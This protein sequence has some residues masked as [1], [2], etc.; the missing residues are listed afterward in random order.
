MVNIHV[1][2]SRPYKHSKHILRNDD[3]FT[4]YLKGN[5][6]WFLGETFSNY[7]SEMLLSQSYN[8]ISQAIIWCYR[9]QFLKK[10][11]I[12][13]KVRHQFIWDSFL[14]SLEVLHLTKLTFSYQNIYH[15]YIIKQLVQ[16]SISVHFNSSK[17]LGNDTIYVYR[18]Y[19]ISFQVVRYWNWGV[20][21]ILVKLVKN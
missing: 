11:R 10:Y 13:I 16:G 1:Y 6:C 2:V 9:Y 12:Q 18:L 5:Y 3:T 20:H 4:K 7:L 19:N 21:M 14:F 15:I 8:K 17:A